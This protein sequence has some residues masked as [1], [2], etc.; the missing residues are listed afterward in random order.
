MEY[1]VDVTYHSV[2]FEA[3][4]HWAK[5]FDKRYIYRISNDYAPLIL[6]LLIGVRRNIPENRRRLVP[7]IT[8][9]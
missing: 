9:F 4:I 6:K 2:D 5:K 3:A 7:I 1:V 8:F